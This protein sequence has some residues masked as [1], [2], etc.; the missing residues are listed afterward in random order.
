VLGP[1]WIAALIWAL[2]PQRDPLRSSANP[3]SHDDFK[4]TMDNED[5]GMN[6]GETKIH[7]RMT[8]FKARPLKKNINLKSYNFYLSSIIL[9]E[10]FD[11]LEIFDFDQSSLSWSFFESETEV[12][13]SASGVI[14]V[15]LDE[16]ELETISSLTEGECAICAVE[17]EFKLDGDS[18]SLIQGEDYELVDSGFCEITLEEE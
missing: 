15:N 14:I 12:E 8:G 7:I 2:I 18:A 3:V 10:N 4:D 1:L 16:D 11:D 6:Q 17:I 13:I 5:F 9:D